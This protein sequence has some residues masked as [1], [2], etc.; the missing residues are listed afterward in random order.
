MILMFVLYVHTSFIKLLTWFFYK[1]N[2]NCSL[3]EIRN[4]ALIIGMKIQASFRDFLQKFVLWEHA[5][6]KMFQKR[7]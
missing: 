7:R 2:M 4:K 1:V 3:L 5:Q 6:N